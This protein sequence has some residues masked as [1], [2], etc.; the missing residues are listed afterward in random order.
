MSA[1]RL[2]NRAG[3]AEK[4]SSADVVVVKVSKKVLFLTRLASPVSDLRG[5]ATTYLYLFLLGD[6]PHFLETRFFSWSLSDYFSQS[7][8]FEVSISLTQINT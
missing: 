8:I 3:G 1:R 6:F 2:R 5:A 7:Q 4:A